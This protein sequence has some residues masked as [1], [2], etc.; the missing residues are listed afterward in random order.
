MS[1]TIMLTENLGELIRL[2]ETIMVRVFTFSNY[3]KC[4]EIY[5]DG[6]LQ[7]SFCGDQSLIDELKYEQES[8]LKLIDNIER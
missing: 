6:E 2:S 3:I 4:I 7:K 1:E 8:L 5:L